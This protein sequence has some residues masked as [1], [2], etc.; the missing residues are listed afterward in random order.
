[1]STYWASWRNELVLQWSKWMETRWCGGNEARGKARSPKKASDCKLTNTN[2]LE[3]VRASNQ[4][5]NQGRGGNVKGHRREQS[6]Q[7]SLINKQQKLMPRPRG[8]VTAWYVASRIPIVGLKWIV[9]WRL[10]HIF[11]KQG[12]LSNFVSPQAT[13]RWMVPSKC[14][15]WCKTRRARTHVKYQLKVF[16]IAIFTTRSKFDHQM[17]SSHF[18]IYQLSK[19][20]GKEA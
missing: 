2:E 15:Q 6:Y 3:E 4:S 1:M 11:P 14:D 12:F 19:S 5:G 13:G 17:Q 10:K 18:L 16:L 20:H 7:Y 8:N 9:W